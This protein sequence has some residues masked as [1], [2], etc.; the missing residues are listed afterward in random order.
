MKKKKK[1]FFAFPFCNVRRNQVKLTCFI[2]T[3]T[4]KVAKVR[5]K[6]AASVGIYAN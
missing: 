5:D 6:N 2:I 3:L 1:N 4:F